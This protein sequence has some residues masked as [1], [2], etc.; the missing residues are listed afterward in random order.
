MIKIDK[1]RKYMVVLDTETCPM[2]KTD[3]VDPHN[4]L[5][6]DIGWSIVD[7]TGKVYISRSYM[8]GETFGCPNLMASAYYADKIPNYI[9]DLIAGTRTIEHLNKI[10]GQL[11]SDMVA[12][13]CTEV[14]A[15][16]AYFDY[17]T[18]NNT[19]E[20]FSIG[21][22]FFPYAING[23][24]VE[25]CDTLKMARDTILKMP[26]YKAFCEQY[27]LYT[28]NGRLSATAENLYRFITNNP[29]FIESHTALEDVTIEK[30]ILAYCYKMHK[31]MRKNLF[32]KKA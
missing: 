10:K 4:M 24:R 13:N 26:T 32:A 21:R 18:L 20:Y 3:S 2:V 7:K 16:N 27:N 14:Y 1:R 19:M 6:Y 15:H 29:Y 30:E 11:V 23:K 22:Y 25:V 28:A 8:V 17:T 31:K 9:N 12:Y 5:A